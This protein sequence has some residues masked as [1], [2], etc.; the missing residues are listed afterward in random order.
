MQDL[1]FDKKGEFRSGGWILLFILGWVL[2]QALYAL[3]LEPMA[4]MGLNEDCLLAD[5]W[6][7]F[8]LMLLAAWPCLRM[9][10]KPF[11]SLGLRPNWRWMKELALGT[12]F[13]MGLM[14]LC[15]LVILAFGGFHWMATPNVHFKDLV[16]GFW[17][18]LAV[19]FF[20]ELYFRG[21][22]FQRLVD[23]LGEWPALVLVSIWFAHAHWDNPGMS[24][25]TRLW[26]TV[27][28]GLAGLLLGLCYLR[29]RSLALPIGLHLGW[30]WAQGS[31]L[32]FGV[33]GTTDAPGLLTPVFHGR[34]E[35]LT[36]GAFGLEASLPCALL[37]L[38]AVLAL[39]LW[40]RHG[41]VEE[42][43]H[44]G[45]HAHAL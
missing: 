44:S 28:I 21:Y 25:A 27:N 12:A 7:P 1:L 38:A 20:E 2:L 5:Y 10:R 36:G 8:G 16:E 23:G 24:G 18:Y 35:W 15:A 9:Q 40:R 32:G 29:T 30:N 17:L 4:H 26:A 19:A 22:I 3:A 13:G 43:L 39:A 11:S 45:E 37:C 42:P 34:P 31:L 41:R 6:V 14:G 33:S